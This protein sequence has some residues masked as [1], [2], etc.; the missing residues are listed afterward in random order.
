[1]SDRTPFLVLSVVHATEQ[2]GLDGSIRSS[3]ALW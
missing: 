1:V 2:Q 3:N